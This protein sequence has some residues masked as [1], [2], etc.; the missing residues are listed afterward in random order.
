MNHILKLNISWIPQSL[1]TL[2]NIIHNIVKSQYTN[3]ERAVFGKGE[4]QLDSKFRHFS[5][6]RGAWLKKTPDQQ[7]RHVIRMSKALALQNPRQCVT[8]SD[9]Q[10][11]TY[12]APGGREKPG[13][14]KRLLYSTMIHLVGSCASKET[15][16]YYYY[17]YYYYHYKRELATPGPARILQFVLTVTAN[18]LCNSK[19]FS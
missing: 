13:Q 15:I 12:S 19:E 17:Y 5:V 4:Y 3:V 16:Y 6:A 2:I 14:V 1:P 8:S 11:R 18:K 9:S 10:C 7:A